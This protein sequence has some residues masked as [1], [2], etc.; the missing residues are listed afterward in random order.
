MLVSSAMDVVCHPFMAPDGG[1]SIVTR[2]SI[3]VHRVIMVTSTVCGTDLYAS[4]HQKRKSK[5]DQL[6]QLNSLPID[7]AAFLSSPNFLNRA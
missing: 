4:Q 2:L 5:C 6:K 7:M 3:S 1:V